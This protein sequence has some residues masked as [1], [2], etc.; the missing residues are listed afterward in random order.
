[1]SGVLWAVVAGIGFGLF[2]T[3]HRKAGEGID[4]I[5][6][7][8]TLIIVSA[9]V[10]MVV[11]ILTGELS[12]LWTAPIGAVLAFIIA[13]FIHFFVGWT[14][15][16]ISQEQIGAA[17]TSAIVGT[18][19]LFGLGV[20]VIVYQETFS[21]TALFGIFLVVAGVYIISTK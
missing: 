20:D 11:I 17:R 1:M 21:I 9:L 10:L 13:G 2:Q 7:T 14:L 4:A 5:R 8:F 18:M 12:L 3:V 16:S 15:I 19:P 6:G